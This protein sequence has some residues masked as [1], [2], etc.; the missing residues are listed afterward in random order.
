MQDIQEIFSRIQQNKKKMK[1]LKAAYKDG[2]AASQEYVEADETLKVAREKRKSIEA[3][4][5]DGFSGEF[6]QIE[7]LK[8]D[9]ASDQ[10]LLSDVAMTKMMN[11]ET[12]ELKDEYDN[13][14]SPIMK[15]TFKKVN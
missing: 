8:I 13:D 7:D 4:V 9:I 3:K 15:V 14:F 11:G 1:D 10:E 2:L 6:T 5:R 12:V